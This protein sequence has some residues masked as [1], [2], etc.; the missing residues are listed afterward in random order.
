MLIVT[1]K[2]EETPLKIF[3]SGNEASGYFLIQKDILEMSRNK[4]SLETWLQLQEIGG[5]GVTV[6]KSPEKSISCSFFWVGVAASRWQDKFFCHWSKIKIWWTPDQDRHRNWNHRSIEVLILF[7]PR[8]EGLGLVNY[9]SSLFW[10]PWQGLHPLP[11]GRTGIG[12][13]VALFH[14]LRTYLPWKYDSK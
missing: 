2:G 13:I 8:Q 11:G 9:F 10:V 14:H 5:E 7:G 4:L 3:L 12:Q 1:K 6:F